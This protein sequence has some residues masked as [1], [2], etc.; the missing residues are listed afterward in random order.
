LRLIGLGVGLIATILI[1]FALLLFGV[2]NPRH[3]IAAVFLLSGLWALVFGV[4]MENRR[5]SL[6][7][8]GFGLLVALLSTAVVIQF[9]YTLGLELLALVGLALVQAIFRPGAAPRPKPSP[10]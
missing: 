9:R 10:G 6:Y 8:S 7:Y 3:T 1:P 2:L 5:E 4:L